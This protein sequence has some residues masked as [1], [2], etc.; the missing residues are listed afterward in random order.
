MALAAFSLQLM[1]IMKRT[2]IFDVVNLKLVWDHKLFCRK[3]FIT[4]IVYLW[5]AIFTENGWTPCL[6]RQC[7]L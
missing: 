7:R 5:F 6:S 4:E 2:N 1:L 3:L